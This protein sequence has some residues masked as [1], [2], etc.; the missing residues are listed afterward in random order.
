MHRF[1]PALAVLLLVSALA[2]ACDNGGD[3]DETGDDGAGQAAAPVTVKL[4][5]F[6]F[7]P[8]ELQASPGQT[9]TVEVE[10][11]GSAAHTFTIDE[12]GVDQ[13]LPPGETGTVLVTTQ[14][15]GTLRM[16]CRFHERQAMEGALKVG[17][18][19]G[20]SQGGTAPVGNGGGDIGY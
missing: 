2:L 20:S 1:L 16:Y 3:G 14:E 18:G 10:N 6:F 17:E 19:P 12:L 11:E 5:E 8:G 13:V 9:L 4:G 7:Q 15:E